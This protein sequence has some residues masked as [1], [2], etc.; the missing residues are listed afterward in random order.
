MTVQASRT[1]KMIERTIPWATLVILAVYTYTF[2]FL[3]PYI[4]FEFTRG[5]VSEIFVP[6]SPE[7][8]QIGDQL[9]RVGTVSLNAFTN[10]LSQTIF[11]SLETDQSISLLV[12]RNGQEFAFDWVHPGSDQDQ[13]LQRFNGLWWLPYVFWMAG[14]ATLLFIRPKDVRWILLIAFNYLTAIWLAAGSG[15]S[16]WHVWQSAIVLRS[17]MWLCLPVYLHFHWVFPQPIRQLPIIVWGLIYLS[18][19]TF[20]ILEWFLVPPVSAY[21]GGFLLAIMGSIV[22]LITHVIFQ[23]EHRRD[24]GLLAL[25][26]MLVVIPPLGISIITLTGQQPPAFIQGGAFLAFP[27]LPGGYFYIAYRRQFTKLRHREKRLIIYY[28][29]AI[30]VGTVFITVLSFIDIK[31][32]LSGSTL[33]PGLAFIMLAALIAITSFFPFL[34]LPALAGSTYAVSS[35]PDGMEFRANRLLSFYLFT[36][37]AGTVL[38]LGIIIADQLIDFPGK[39]ILIGVAAM[40]FAGSIT[41]IGFST[42]QHFVD[43][44]ILGIR[45][46]PTHLLETYS[47]RITTSLEK[48]SLVRLITNEV[49]PSLFIR[50]SALVRLEDDKHIAAYYFSRV[51]DHQLPKDDDIPFLLSQVGGFRSRPSSSDDEQPLS[52]IRVILPLK[53]GG[54]LLGLWL[55]GCRDPDD[56]YALAEISVLQTIT[57][58]TAIAFVNIEQAERLRALH[59]AN[60]E[61]HELERTNLARDLHDDVLNQLAVLSMKVDQEIAPDFEEGFQTVT[62]RLRQMISGLRPA[63]LNYGLA[64]ALEELTDE[65]SARIE[66]DV[67]IQ[68]EISS[69]GPQHDPMVEAH[70]YRIVQQGCENALRH[71]QASTVQVHGNCDPER[72]HIIVEDDGIGFSEP[73]QLDFKQLLADKHYGIAG[74][75][76]RAEIIGA[77]LRFDSTPGE[78]TKISV[79]WHPENKE[80]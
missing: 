24:I 76:E 35:K 28:L 53:V 71:A 48:T 46:P 54:D 51:E 65:L 66:N 80:R 68:V 79:S 17:V 7:S 56:Y 75:F 72:V 8:I 11:D 33:L 27:A 60:V 44:H 39:T 32:G 31:V 13:I 55:L 5:E 57:N 45:L 4:G 9:L 70:L 40:L 61:R 23:K 1:W 62:A 6:T 63:M 59:Q 74:M 12:E 34:S 25:A 36:V 3:V 16:H 19:I 41:A 67:D 50:E 14:T 15:P 49:L 52:W 78:G 58:Q 69:S 30:V 20:A 21:Y 73:D 37:I 22:F 43:R 29:L 18:G 38:T 42:F 47:E 2:F 10:D 26:I 64:P 77:E